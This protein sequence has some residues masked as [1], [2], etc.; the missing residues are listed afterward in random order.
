MFHP[1]ISLERCNL[2]TTDTLEKVSQFQSPVTITC[3]GQNSSSF[4]IFSIYID[5]SLSSLFEGDAPA[6]PEPARPGS[7]SV[8]PVSLALSPVRSF[9]KFKPKDE[10]ALLSAE[11]SRPTQFHLCRREWARSCLQTWRD[12]RGR[13]GAGKVADRIGWNRT[14]RDGTGLPVLGGGETSWSP[15]GDGGFPTSHAPHSMAFEP[16]S[17]RGP[18]RPSLRRPCL[19]F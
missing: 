8:S 16:G 9:W 4:V 17:C 11:G 10:T 6:H 12:A 7:L 2:P 19:S 18:A 3:P 13:D 5:S 14:G 15:L 1:D